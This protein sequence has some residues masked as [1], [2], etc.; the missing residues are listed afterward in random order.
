MVSWRLSQ[1]TWRSRSVKHPQD[2]MG[3]RAEKEHS[4]HGV[5][6]GNSPCSTQHRNGVMKKLSWLPARCISG[7]SSAAQLSDFAQLNNDASALS[8]AEPLQAGQPISA[9]NALTIT[10]M[11][12][13]IGHAQSATTS[14]LMHGQMHWE[15]S[16]SVMLSP[17]CSRSYLQGERERDRVRDG[18]GA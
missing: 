18:R 7:I 11:S 14:G 10:S 2:P 5:T 15:I 16:A 17:G 1:V 3:R 6:P 13:Q 8:Q 12:A 4:E 9:L